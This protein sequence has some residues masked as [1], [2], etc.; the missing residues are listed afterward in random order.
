MADIGTYGRMA[1][2]VYRDDPRVEGW[3]RVALR[4]S[5]EGLLDAFQG[6]AFQRGTEVV[7]A[8]KGT[9]QKRDAAADVQLAIGM[10]SVQYSDAMAFVRATRVNPGASVLLCGHSLG[11]AIAQV[12]GNRL[13]LRF[14]TFNAPGVAVMSRNLDEVAVS[15]GAGTLAVR[16]LGTAASALLHPVQAAQDARAFFR[17]ARGVNFRVGQDVVGCTG[18]HYGQVV[19]IPYGGGAPDV[20][21]KHRMTT[22]LAELQRSGIG[23]RELSAYLA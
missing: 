10:N 22:V 19:E 13:G 8:F 5:G 9:S 21:A 3:D 23:R 15:A 7:F 20:M 16:V 17:T 4:P 11:G 18:V 6:A 14:V 1:D 2:A 12:V